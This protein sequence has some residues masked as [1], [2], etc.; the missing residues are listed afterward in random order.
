MMSRIDEVGAWK[1]IV[2]LIELF[3]IFMC[4]DQVRNR[5]LTDNLLLLSRLPDFLARM[6]YVW[7]LIKKWRKQ[8]DEAVF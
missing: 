8:N 5:P 3:A 1:Q 2:A 4:L 6:D 7:E